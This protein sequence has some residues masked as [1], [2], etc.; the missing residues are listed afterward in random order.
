M[1][2]GVLLGILGLA[3]LSAG[4]SY[5]TKFEK[6]ITV[7]GKFERVRGNKDG[8]RQIFSVSDTDNNVYEVSPSFWYW[9]WYSTETW[10]RLKSGETY[11]VKGYGLR[12][13]P[14]SLYPNIIFAEQIAKKNVK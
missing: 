5:G 14:L 7:D 2:R 8:V 11:R 10:N 6:E 1:S 13:G 12:C 3:G 9:K 4:Y